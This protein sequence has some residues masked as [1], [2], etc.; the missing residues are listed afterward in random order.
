[1]RFKT[2]SRLRE[3]NPE[4]RGGQ[5]ADSKISPKTNLKLGQ[6]LVLITCKDLFLLWFSKHPNSQKVTLPLS[7]ISPSI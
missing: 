3:L 1:M 5:D 7:V 2:E 6:H 4:A